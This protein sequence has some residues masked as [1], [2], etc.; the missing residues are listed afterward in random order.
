LTNTLN[1]YKSLAFTI[2]VI[3]IEVF[4]GQWALHTRTLHRNL[5]SLNFLI[6]FRS[7]F[8]C[9]NHLFQYFTDHVHLILVDWFNVGQRNF[10][11]YN[12]TSAM[13]RDNITVT[14]KQL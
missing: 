4:R 13:F 9:S 3:L 1:Y 8:P 10:L 14:A 12:L 7:H 11:F 2:G 5:H 6:F